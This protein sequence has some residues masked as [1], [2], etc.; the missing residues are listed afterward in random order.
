MKKVRKQKP[1]SGKKGLLREA[2]KDLERE[3]RNLRSSR[4]A[5]ET[6]SKGIGASLGSA[7]NKEIILRNQIS[8]LMKKE[9]ALEK[10]KTQTK[11]QLG[12]L[13]NKIEKV[14]SIEREL[15]EV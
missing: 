3:L 6:K 4:L 15:K 2:L 14:K 8:E 13:N 12:E 5:L 9:A 1:G 10:K 11:D 7:Q